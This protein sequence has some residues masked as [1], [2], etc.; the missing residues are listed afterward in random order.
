MESGGFRKQVINREVGS[1][2]RPW[3][4]GTD[5]VYLL[6]EKWQ[7]IGTKFMIAKG[8][9]IF[10]TKGIISVVQGVWGHVLYTPLGPWEVVSSFSHGP[11]AR[12]V[13]PSYNFKLMWHAKLVLGK[14]CCVCVWPAQD[15]CGHSSNHIGSWD[16]AKVFL[17]MRFWSTHSCFSLTLL[18]WIC[19]RC[20]IWYTL[21]RTEKNPNYKIVH[22]PLK[23]LHLLVLIVDC[24]T[25]DVEHLN[26]G[27]FESKSNNNGVV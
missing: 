3:E 17:G 27:S 9:L 14:K 8:L 24:W 4:L 19:F 7:S 16:G 15:G 25:S 11:L 22:V 20:S 1:G 6:Q 13:R 26:G 23:R 5:D 12:E 21:R 10:F 18:V 2:N